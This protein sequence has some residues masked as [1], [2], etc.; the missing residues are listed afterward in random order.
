[1]I[2]TL[3]I[4]STA[5]GWTIS[6]CYKVKHYGCASVDEENG[7]RRSYLMGPKV[8]EQIYSKVAR[9][10]GGVRIIAEGVFTRGSASDAPIMMTHGAIMTRLLDLFPAS[11]WET[12]QPT[13]W[14]AKVIPAEMKQKY[15]LVKNGRKLASK[16]MASLLGVKTDNDNIADAVCILKYI[17]YHK[18]S[19]LFKER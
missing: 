8:A 2:I 17:Q 15:K 18:P 19:L 7:C 11:I 16:E 13:T 6:H 12:V 10:G 4:S 3:D 5:T 9:Y 14:Y 1:M